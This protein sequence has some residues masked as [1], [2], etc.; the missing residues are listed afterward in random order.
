MT[1]YQAPSLNAEGYSCPICGWYARQNFSNSVSCGFPTIGGV[2]L[3]KDYKLRASRCEKCKGLM[4]WIGDLIVHPRVTAGPP[5]NEDMPGDVRGDYVEAQSIANYSPRAAGAL[6]RL[7][8]QKLC[9]SLGEPGKDINT[10]IG[11]LVSKGLPVRIQ[12]ALD[13][14]RVVGN[15][16]VHPGTMDLED[17]I[18]TVTKLFELVNLIVQ[19]Q[20]TDPKAIDTL[21]GSLPTAKLKGIEDRDKKAAT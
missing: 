16:C 20:I 5:P 6:L 15:E 1:K 3:T 13:I 10:D 12:K 2:D 18:E 14:L 19:D 8:I 7:S 9:K 4:L 17:D 11:S 21:Y